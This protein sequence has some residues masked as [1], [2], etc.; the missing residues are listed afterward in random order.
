MQG[1]WG[2]LMNYLKWVV[3][4]TLQDFMDVILEI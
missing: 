4:V 2:M 1:V 3:G